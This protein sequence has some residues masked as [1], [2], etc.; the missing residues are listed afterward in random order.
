M[1]SS[2]CNSWFGRLATLLV[3]FVISGAIAFAQTKTVTGTIVDDL[4]EPVI[5]ANV[6]VAGTTNGATTDIDGNFSIQNVAENATL[7]VTYIG[8]TEQQ[9][10]VAGKSKFNITLTEDHSDLEEVV[11]VGYGTMKRKDLTGSVASVTGDKLASNPVSNVAQALQGQLPGVNV[12]SQ[13]GRP[14]ASMSIRVRGGGSITQSND[15]LFIVDGVAVSSIDDIPADNIESID[16]LKDAASTAIYGAR[17]ANGV[18]LVTTKG[19]KEGKALVKYG[20]YYQL[21]T[22]P[23]ILEMQDA[24]NH[25]VWNWGYATALGTTYADNIAKYYGLGSKYG[26]HINEYK[27]MSSHNYMEDVLRSTNSWNHDLS[28]SGGT[29]KTKYYASLNYSN[30]EG[31]LINSGFKRINANIKLSQDINKKLKWDMN[32]RYGEMQFAGSRYE[33]ATQSSQYKPIDNPLGSGV[34]S[35]LGMGSQYAEDSYNPVSVIEDYDNIRKTNR[36]SAT[37]GLTWKVIKGLTAKS[38]LT[39]GRYWREN[40]FWAGGHTAGQSKNEAKLTNQNGYNVNWN[41]TLSYDVQGLPKA[42]SLNVMV[43]NEVLASK[44][45]TATIDGYGY[46]TEWDMEHAFGNMDV[47][48]DKVQSTYSRIIGIPSHTLSW[49]GRVNYNL[50]GRYMLT[51]TMRADGSSKFSGDN[52]WGYFPAA[53]VAWRLSDEAFME[54]T[55]D[56]LDNLKIRLS[57]GTSG[58]DGIDGSLFTTNWVSGTDTNTGNTVYKPTKTLGNPDLKWETTTSRNAGIDYSILNGRVNGA[59]DAYWNT[60]D[61]CLMLVPCDPTSGFSYQMQNVAKTSNKGLEFSANYAII[62]R[63]DFNLSLGFRYNFNVNKVEELAEGVNANAQTGW[64]STTRNNQYDYIVKVGE[65]VGL[66]QGFEADGFYTVDDFDVEGGQWKLKSGVP[67]CT[68]AYAG[69]DAYN[70]PAGQKAF[71]GVAKFKDINEDGVVDKNDVTIIGR[72]PSRHTGGFNINGNWKGLDFTLNFAYQ[73]GG[74]VQNVNVM[75]DMY[76]DK[77]TA[78]GRSRLAEVSRCWR[79]YDINNAGE[80]YAVT[81]PDELRRLNAG[82][83]HALN[84]NEAGITSSQYVEDASFLR[85]QNLTLGYSLPKGLIQKAGLSSARVYFTGGNLFCLK[86]YSGIDPDVNV[87]PAGDSNYSGFPTPGYD[88]HSYPKTR[89]F[90]F[91]LNVAF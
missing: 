86:K 6:I 81:D 43:G 23:E 60:T 51:A 89:T 75:K 52:H 8:Y 2:K 84:Y 49:F 76:G 47:T 42:H 90:T 7:K 54:N 27:N 59:I 40:Q 13:D 25:V 39:L 64:A 34:A 46:P 61:D 65:P 66:I 85:L 71:P 72:V 4:G 36:I 3:A 74:R 18:I 21:K 29:E 62:R 10:K 70:L 91:G 53:A 50:L 82:A 78:L 80:I 37:N 68:I 26:N 19:A 28:I 1:R 83:K 12:T 58:N 87:S 77:D 15:P 63:K 33:Y 5:G 16:V 57:F 48:S 55:K 67:D 41:S 11:V 24:Y 20:M 22:K 88:Y 32:V 14:G 17:G 31:T 38:E 9:I 79:M 69:G 56:W 73:L 30:D 44:S 35:D 45:T